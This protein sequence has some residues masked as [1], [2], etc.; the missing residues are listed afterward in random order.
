MFE[1]DYDLK[2]SLWHGLNVFI[3]ATKV[4]V[5]KK[6]EWNLSGKHFEKH[7]M[8]ASSGSSYGEDGQDGQDGYSG[9]SSGNIMVLAEQI[10]HAQNLSVILNGGHG[11]D[12]QDAGDGANGKDG[13][14]NTL[15][16]F[17]VTIHS[18]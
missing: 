8:K 13:T 17:V 12:G 14:G 6:C 15:L 18:P 16:S 2:N 3:M 1:I 11:S 10:D 5:S 7:F 9:E 4:N